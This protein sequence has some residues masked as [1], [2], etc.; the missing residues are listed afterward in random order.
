MPIETPIALA[1]GLAVAGVG[2][3]A[4]GRRLLAA[5][6][7][8]AVVR[9]GWCEAATGLLWALS[10]RGG[11][12]PWWLP[13]PLAVSWFGV[14]LTATDLSHLRLPDA[15]TLPAY[16]AVAVLVGVAAAG[17]PG[18][19]LAVRACLGALVLWGGYAAVRAVAPSA[20]GGGDVKLA[21]SLGGVLGAVGWP[22]LVLA[23]VAA[24]ACTLALWLICSRR[25]SAPVAHGPGMLAA[26]WLVAA[27]PGAGVLPP[28]LPW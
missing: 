4:A 15:L 25:W 19:G 6:A 9:A 21:G 16:P 18:P 2:A 17:G 5:M 1:V 3:G 20:L 10:I 28:T 26:T 27:F 13:V 11:T 23:T 7:R 22:A 12:P 24:S 8:G 14:L